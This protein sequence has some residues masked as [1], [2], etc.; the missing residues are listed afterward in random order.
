[1]NQNEQ[2][3]Y[4]KKLGEK[5]RI[6]REEFEYRIT[7]I[8]KCKRDINYFASKYFRIISLDSGL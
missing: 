3:S 6:S 8:A 1:M 5:D 2:L 7:E 4:I